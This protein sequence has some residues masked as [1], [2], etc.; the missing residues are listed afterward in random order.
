VVS[1]IGYAEQS[2]SWID[3]WRLGKTIVTVLKELG[4]E[5]ETVRKSETL[6][7]LLTSHQRWFDVK[8]IG[9]KPTYRILESLLKDGDVRQFLEVNRYNDILW[10]NKE[11]FDE[12][13]Q[14]LFLIAVVEITSDPHLP[15]E[16]MAREEESCYAVVKA[17][18][19]AETR[20]DYQVEK[21]LEKARDEHSSRRP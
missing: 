2:R 4:M 18:R 14:W 13:L 6:I 11:A 19:E 8:S 16:E 21:L 1:P 3:E 5:E 10:F 15:N 9:Q 17:L 7:K 20:S 12:L